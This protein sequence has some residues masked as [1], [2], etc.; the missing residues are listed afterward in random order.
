VVHQ[1]V[2]DVLEEVGLVGAEEASG[3]LVH[4]LLQLRDAVV[5]GLG[6]VAEDA[7]GFRSGKVEQKLPSVS[8]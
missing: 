2:D 1:H 7:H 4:G 6:V 3:D 5:V 8:R